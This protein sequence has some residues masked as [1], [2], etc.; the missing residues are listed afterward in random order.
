MKSGSELKIIY[1]LWWEYLRRSK[2]Y[3]KVCLWFREI[4]DKN[5][6]S[7]LEVYNSFIVYLLYIMEK[8]SRVPFYVMAEMTIKSIQLNPNKHNKAT[9]FFSWVINSKFPFNNEML[10]NYFIF[11]DIFRNSFDDYYKRA[12]ML[13]KYRTKFQTSN[14]SDLTDRIDYIIDWVEESAIEELG[15]KPTLDEYKKH[16]R[17]WFVHDKFHLYTCIFI[18]S[19]ELDKAKSYISRLIKYRRKERKYIEEAKYY[20]PPFTERFQYPTGNIRIAEIERYLNTFDFKKG[21]KKNKEIAKI[22]YPNLEPTDQN[23][24]RRVQRDHKN[25]KKIIKNVETGFFPGNY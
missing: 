10:L 7:S 22:T 2:N 15:R 1:N 23:T 8:D 17:D 12:D 4:I 3:K 11:G 25:A 14:Y 20:L 18:P 5:P 9:E 13:L 21:G 6:D 19:I 24:I 16:L